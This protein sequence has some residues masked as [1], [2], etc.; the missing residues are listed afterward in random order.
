MHFNNKKII[1][2]KNLNHNILE[3]RMSLFM[4][5]SVAEQ[6]FIKASTISVPQQLYQ[7]T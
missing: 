5:F 1:F 7:T 4:L 2:F 3:L 6:D